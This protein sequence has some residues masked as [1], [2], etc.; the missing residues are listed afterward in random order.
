MGK[1]K[2]HWQRLVAPWQ[3]VVSGKSVLLSSSSSLE[4]RKAMTLSPDDRFGF[5]VTVLVSV[6]VTIRREDC[7]DE[8]HQPSLWR[9][10][11]ATSRQDEIRP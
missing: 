1:V 8:K 10:L 5:V 9:L 11:T 2:M 7:V 6:L 3:I 4:T